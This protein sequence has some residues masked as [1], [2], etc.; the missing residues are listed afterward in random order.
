MGLATA[1]NLNHFSMHLHGLYIW[2]LCVYPRDQPFPVSTKRYN[3]TTVL[4][5]L[6][7]YTEY[8]APIIE[9]RQ[10]YKNRVRDYKFKGEE[11]RFSLKHILRFTYAIL[12][13][14]VYIY[15]EAALIEQVPLNIT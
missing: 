8:I 15:V 14:R 2:C 11:L 13:T 9:G 1:E 12:A 5:T 10:Y 6:R 3:N 4:L 7:K